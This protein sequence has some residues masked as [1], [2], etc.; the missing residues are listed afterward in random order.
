MI[1]AK[2]PP[3]QIPPLIS[4]LAENFGSPSGETE[5][6]SEHSVELP[7][8][9]PGGPVP[10]TGPVDWNAA[11]RNFP[12]VGGN[13]A[14]QR[15][16]SLAQI[17][18]ANVTQL[19][20]AWRTHLN[21]GNPRGN[22]QGT[23]VVVDGV[24][25]VSDGSDDV[26]AFDAAT[27]QLRWKY[28]SDAKLGLPTNRGVVVADGA[29]FE[30]QRDNSLIALN[31]QTG[32]LLWK[33]QIAPPGSGYADAPAVYYDGLVY[34]GLAGGDGGV[35]GQFVAY[36][37]RT[38]R[39][40]WRFWTVPG[41]GETG[42]NTWE[43]DSWKHGGGPVWTQPAIDPKLGLIYVGVGNAW[44]DT[45]GTQRGGD[46]LFT[47][48]IVALDLR[49]GKLKWYY[50]EVHHDLWDYDNVDSPVL[51]DIRMRG[52]V[53]KA[54]INAGKSGYL[55]ILDRTNGKP[56]VPIP[57]RPVPQEP[58]IKTAA[59][60][61][62]PEGDSFVPTCPEKGSVP[63]GL[64]S[65]CIFGAYWTD[66]VVMTPG[67]QGG[68]SW[69]PITF[70]P[71]TGLVYVPGSIINSAYALRRQEWDETEN[72]PKAV[73]GSAGLGFYRPQGEPRAGTLTAMDPRTNKIAWQIRTEY[74]LGTGSGLLSTAGGL[75]F[76]GSSDGN[77]VAYD[78]GNGNALWRF[79]TGVGA[80]APVVTYEVK[81]V[82]Y[83]AVLAGGNSFQLSARGDNLWAFRL[84]G[85]VKPAP[86]PAPPP[87]RQPGATGRSPNVLRRSSSPR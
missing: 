53:R 68:A 38:G 5:A 42:H 82:Q 30:G 18:R 47:S 66:P 87:L 52:R 60:Q 2:V 10:P 19:G 36:D 51:A 77:L 44:P 75:L 62:I 21:R 3:E 79:Q 73:S 84:G 43:G 65:S 7:P 50:Q 16:S 55:Y 69:A 37:A 1:G 24:M 56:L 59:T 72:R 32:E 15:F 34:M 40:V 35:R 71:K 76:G 83:V 64:K 41:P 11:G 12:A 57:E 20:G 6:A 67:T 85:K 4:Y 81:G 78:I 22:M 29:V 49:T 17:N 86:A 48:S 46:N 13:L 31:Q 28:A 39:Q 70:D 80:D 9:I 54:L 45:D 58:R 25:Y 14:N 63:A 61:P 23:P 27:G 33:A 8:L 74:P 26:F